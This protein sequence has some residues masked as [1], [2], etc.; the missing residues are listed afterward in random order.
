MKN[1]GTYLENESLLQDRYKIKRVFT[2]NELCITYQAFDT[3]REKLV[4]VKEL[5]PRSE[6]RRVGKECFRPLRS[7]GL[8]DH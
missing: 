5:Y 2:E 4:F 8:P 1:K 3:L 6:E 7:G